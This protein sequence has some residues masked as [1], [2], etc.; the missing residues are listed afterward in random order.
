MG[1][2]VTTTLS[3]VPWICAPA[4]AEM[5]MVATPAMNMERSISKLQKWKRTPK[6]VLDAAAKPPEMKQERC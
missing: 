5:A 2:A 6:S 1:E 3:V 4:G